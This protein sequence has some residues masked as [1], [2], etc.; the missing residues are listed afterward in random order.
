MLRLDTIEAL[1]GH[2]RAVMS[3]PSPTTRKLINMKAPSE[4]ATA[5]PYDIPQPGREVT[6]QVVK[7]F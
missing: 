4:S 6:L 7:S 3:I 5:V 1:T 2:Q